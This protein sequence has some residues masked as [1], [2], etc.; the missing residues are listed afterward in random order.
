[1]PRNKYGAERLAANADPLTK[2]RG[3][4]AL[5]RERRRGMPETRGNDEKPQ[6]GTLLAHL[7]H[8]AIGALVDPDTLASGLTLLCAM[9]QEE[10]PIIALEKHFEALLERAHTVG[11]ERRK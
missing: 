2:V 3:A 4:R 5:E 9:E 10:N 11:V 7:R 8:Y 1:M 6:L